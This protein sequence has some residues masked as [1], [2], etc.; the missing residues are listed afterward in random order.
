MKVE[1]ISE[2][3][4]EWVTEF[5]WMNEKMNKWRRYFEYELNEGWSSQLYNYFEKGCQKNFARDNPER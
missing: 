3:V 4:C 2:W 5:D 1:W